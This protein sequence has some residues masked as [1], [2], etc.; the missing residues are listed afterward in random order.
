MAIPDTLDKLEKRIRT[1]IEGQLV[2]FLP[3]KTPQDL[4]ASLIS[5]SAI[6]LSSPDEELTLRPPPN[7]PGS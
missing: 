7:G 5:L 3:G 2:A 4:L 6:G 1:L